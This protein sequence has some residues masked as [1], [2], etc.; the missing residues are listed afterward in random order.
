MMNIKLLLKQI[1]IPATLIGHRYLAYAIQLCIH[2][3]DYLLS[4]TRRLYEDVAEHFHTN[5]KCVDRD[6]RTAIAR[7]YDH[8][9]W[10][11]LSELANRAISYKTS[12]GEFI[13]IIS[14]YFQKNLNHIA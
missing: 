11:M 8:G 4:I 12:N 9:N 6:I 14:T 1:G 10:T 13:D 3:E 7:A 2:N 5:A